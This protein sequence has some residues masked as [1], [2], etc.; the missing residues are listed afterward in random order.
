MHLEQSFQLVC[1]PEPV[2]PKKGPQSITLLA[3]EVY[4][5][6]SFMLVQILKMVGWAAKKLGGR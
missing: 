5:V 6:V 3:E 4:S 2:T 1:D